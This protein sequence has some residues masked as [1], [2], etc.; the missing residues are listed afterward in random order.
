MFEEFDPKNPT[1][2]EEVHT[3]SISREQR[4]ERKANTERKRKDTEELEDRQM[5]NAVRSVDDFKTVVWEKVEEAKM[6]GRS[7]KKVK[8][9]YGDKFPEF[10]EE[11]K[12]DIRWMDAISDDI[13]L[14]MPYD[15][16][17]RTVIAL[18]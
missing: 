12:Q 18:G 16:S 6:N 9:L 17:E 13:D 8:R 10:K 15:A 3:S 1:P 4:M 14:E 11:A 5:R 7:T 2:K